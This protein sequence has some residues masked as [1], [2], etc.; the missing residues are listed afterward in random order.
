MV[1][2]SQDDPKKNAGGRHPQPRLRAGFPLASL[3]LLVTVLACLLASADIELWRQQQASL[4]A[5]GHWR[6]VVLFVA[7][8]AFGGLVGVVYSFVGATGWRARLMAP[9]SGIVAGSA[10]LL[11]LLAP[12]PLW[13]TV[14]AVSILLVAAVLFRLDAD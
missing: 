10:G 3:A 12:G 6:L 4:V 7:A 5:E 1:T 11:I 8:G 2:I 9:L 14:V 13:K